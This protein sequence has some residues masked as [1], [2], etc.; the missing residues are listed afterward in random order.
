MN[1]CAFAGC[2]N[3]PG[4][5]T[6]LMDDISGTI[7]VAVPNTLLAESVRNNYRLDSLDLLLILT[8]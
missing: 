5:N 8:L 1:F 4:S 2:P 7:L 3:T 6:T